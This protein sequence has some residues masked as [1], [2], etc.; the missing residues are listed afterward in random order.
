MTLAGCS[1]T[2]ADPDYT[3]PAPLPALEQLKQAP[4]TDPAA[5]AAGEDVLAF[6]TA[7]R[8]GQV[9]GLGV[10]QPL[11]TTAGPGGVSAATVRRRLS[12]VSGFTSNRIRCW[13]AVARAA[14][15]ITLICTIVGLLEAKPRDRAERCLFVSSGSGDFSP[16]V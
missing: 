9:A 7:Q 1:V 2:V 3:P 8:T 12:I 11:K 5:F 15:Q 6:V 14:T 13:L 4:L 16:G 10:L